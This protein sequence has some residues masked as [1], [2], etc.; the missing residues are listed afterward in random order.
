M[1]KAKP[2][3][4]IVE[5]DTGLQRQLKWHFSGYNVVVADD[6][7][8][9]IEAV[10]RHEPSVVILD[11]GLPPQEDGV[12]E[13]FRTMREILR[14]A[15]A[16]K[17]IVATGKHDTEHAL[18]AVAMGAYD[19]YPKPIDPDVL[20]LIVT[21]AYQMYELEEQNSELKQRE[22]TP[23]AGF[24]C[25]TPAMLQVCRKIEKLAATDLTCLIHGESGTG[26]E[27]LA[28]TLHNLSP[29]GEH[30][31][32]AINCAAIPETLIES[33]L[34]GYEKGAFTGAD[35]RRIG[36]I[37]A[38]DKGT[39]F[40]DELSDMPASVQ[41]KMLR[42]LQ[43]REI[44]RVGGREKIR[45]DVRIV[46]ATNKDLREMIAT[47][48]FREDLY[49]RICEM[50]IDIPPLR[51][52]GEDKIVLA[53]HLLKKY[54]DSFDRNILNF[55][56]QALAAVD[57]YEW[58]G[59]VREME[60]KIKNAV[61]MC[62]GKFIT[63]FDLGL[64]SNAG[65]TLNLRQ[66]RESAER[67]AVSKALSISSGK[68]ATAAKLLGVTRPTLYDLMQKFGLKKASEK[69]KSD[70]GEASDVSESK[71]ASATR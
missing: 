48:E 35:R 69:N 40:L 42:F 52:R 38:A 51:D 43:E 37:E 23:L 67:T 53:R 59:N 45:V 21:R 3:L 49:F 33:E 44:E 63:A 68:V 60:N 9:A 62:E 61:L 12:E 64:E 71:D 19:F 29:R 41:A 27:L 65:L 2:K 58:P 10:R 46:C 30:P 14:F 16:T 7:D 24:V 57:S 39:L 15:K 36:W 22:I 26:K 25:S 17:I 1:A 18:R 56:E 13:G 8:S 20:E 32:I 11:L 5:D 31:F 54:A 66:V 6:Y 50:Q 55:D 4:L 34:F 28:R 47:G 70:E